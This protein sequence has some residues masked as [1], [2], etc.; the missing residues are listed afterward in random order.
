MIRMVFHI[1]RMSVLNIL[2]VNKLQII[3]KEISQGQKLDTSCNYKI[4]KLMAEMIYI[5][6][7]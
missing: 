5:S 3:N 2:I 7:E 4:H 1:L 6:K